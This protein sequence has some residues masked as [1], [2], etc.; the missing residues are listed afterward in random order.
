MIRISQI[1]LLSAVL[2]HTFFVV[3]N[4]PAQE[5]K[6]DSD[7]ARLPLVSV[8][9]TAQDGPEFSIEYV[10][11]TNKV[12]SITNLL[13][14]S[15]VTLDGAV[16]PHIVLK[17]VGNSTLSPG[18]TISIPIDLG[19]YLPNWLKRDFSTVLKRWRWE[20]PL[21]SGRHTLLVNFGGRVYGPT[22]FMWNAD[23]PL[24]YE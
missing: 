14:S 3:G 21:E 13:N 16:Y 8:F 7:E 19:S 23:V 1:M 18:Q 20:A 5:A 2:G 9:S 17:Y 10:N 24:L 6:P 15:T 11:D 22:T 4:L 12:V